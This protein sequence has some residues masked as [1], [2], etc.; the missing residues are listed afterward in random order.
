MSKFSNYIKNSIIELKKVS[1]P[2]KKETYNYT[3]LV[4]GVSLATAVFL[5]GLDF[6]FNL[7]LEFL[8]K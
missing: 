1:W 4:V 2:T 3:L 7:G 8:I 6:I 5:G